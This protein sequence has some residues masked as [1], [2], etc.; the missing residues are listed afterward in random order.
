[1]RNYL[2]GLRGRWRLLLSMAAVVL[3]IVGAPAIA[4]AQSYP[5]SDALTDATSFAGQ[6]F[7]GAAPIIVAVATAVIGVMLLSWA[8][9]F[10]L[11]KIRA[12]RS[13]VTG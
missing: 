6:T 7:S 4:S 8:I 2:Q 3:G 9:G 5:A 12:K 11:H 1:M 10:V 13:A